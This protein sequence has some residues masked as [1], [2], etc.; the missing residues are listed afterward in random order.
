MAIMESIMISIFSILQITLIDI[1]L[2][3]DNMGVIALAVRNLPKE[4]A[5]MANLIGVSGAI[6]MRVIFA[7]IITTLLMIE[8]L[9]IKLI[10]GLML[11]K[12]TWNLLTIKDNEN[13]RGVNGKRGFWIAVYNIMIADMTMSLDNVLAIG[14]IAHGNIVMIGFGLLFNIPIIFYGSQLVGQLIKKYKITIYIG[15]GI[16]VHTALDMILEDRL[17]ASHIVASFSRL[18]PW[19]IAISIILYGVIDNKTY[20]NKV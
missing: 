15:S 18:F 7:S 1:V 12:V 9:P 3:G 6:V 4:Q 11:L 19:I 16:L 10:G 5:R 14:G 17:I 13:V 20:S 8:W 2:S